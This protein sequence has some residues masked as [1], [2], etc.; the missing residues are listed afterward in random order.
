[1]KKQKQKQKMVSE[2]FVNHYENI[3]TD[4]G[5]ELVK[6]FFITYSRFEFALK[7]SIVFANDRGNRVEPNWDRFINSIRDDFDKS[8]S[9]E[10]LESVTYIIESPP[11]IQLLENEMLVWKARTWQNNPPEINKLRQHISDIRNNLFHGGKFY[12][13][14]Q[15]DVCRNYKLI[16]SGLIILNEW[17]ELNLEV[18]GLFLRRIG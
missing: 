6:N 9:D 10:L 5:K 4:E 13:T 15:E 18:K 17:L 7:G 2:N 16:Y 11:K 3:V 1:M 14:Y 8:S 12:G